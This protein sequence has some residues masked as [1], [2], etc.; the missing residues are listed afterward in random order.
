M[1]SFIFSIISFV[2]A[3]YLYYEFLK[4]GLLARLWLFGSFLGI[5]IFCLGIKM[6]RLNILNTITIFI[7]SFS[8]EENTAFLIRKLKT[9]LEINK[10]KKKKEGI[11][12]EEEN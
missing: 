7:C 10:E 4:E 6:N 12:Q 9:Y 5:L 8:L 2:I 11:M 3:S 1:E